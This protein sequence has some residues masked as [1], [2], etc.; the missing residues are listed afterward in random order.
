MLFVE[1]TE[2]WDEYIIK[3]QLSPHFFYYPA[4]MMLEKGFDVIILSKGAKLSKVPF[5]YNYEGLRIIKFP[6]TFRINQSMNVDFINHFTKYLI[7]YLTRMCRECTLVHMHSLLFIENIIAFLILRKYKIPL[8]FT[9]HYIHW[10]ELYTNIVKKLGSHLIN[11][12]LKFG[13]YELSRFHV[14]TRFQ[15][16]LYARYINSEN[17]VIIP[18]GI[19]PNIFK[20]QNEDYLEKI[21]DKY[22]LK[23]L[24]ILCVANFM[25][26][27][28]QHILI[29]A[30]K[31]I[32]EKAPHLKNRLSLVLV[33]RVFTKQQ[34]DYL[35]EN[36]I[37]RIAKYDLY[38]V[39]KVIID[40]PREDLLYLYLSS[41]IFAL[42]SKIEA[43][44]LVLLEAMAAGLPII[45]T[46]IPPISEI[47]PN[48]EVS[49]LCERK[50]QAFADRILELIWNEKLRKKLGQKGR[51]RVHRE[52]NLNAVKNKLWNLYR[53]L[54]K[55]E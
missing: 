52:Y 39:V 46:N 42:P 55:L 14:F 4:K 28:G 37:Q 54:L 3:K 10:P 40:P 5:A 36:I 11:K 50:A 22:N 49:L 15:A 9:S 43:M 44:P 47:A 7:K 27:K 24:N 30:L 31:L 21:R 25:E 34:R 23:E 2:W 41:D 13:E 1:I 18:H 6:A 32:V 16:N 8:V 26:L 51:E 20:N 19:D 29:D 45:A 38:N 33:G 35:Y 12:C 48:N 53:E 17:L